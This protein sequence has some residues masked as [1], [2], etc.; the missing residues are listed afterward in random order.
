MAD[1][2]T[3]V[4]S[5]RI[6]VTPTATKAEIQKFVNDFQKMLSTAMSGAESP[7]EK[8]VEDFEDAG[9]EAAEKFNKEFDKTKP[10]KKPIDAIEKTTKQLD[11]LYAKMD[12]AQ[13][14]DE[15][16]G[17]SFA[18]GELIDQIEKVEKKLDKLK[19]PPIKV[20]PIDVPP[21]E[22]P[23]EDIAPIE[24][25]IEDIKIPD[26]I[27]PDKIT[28]PPIDA[29]DTSAVEEELD[30]IP[31]G[32]EGIGKKW[33]GLFASGI[34]AA[35]LGGLI[36][37]SIKVGLNF[38]SS[39]TNMS[40]ALGFT[41]EQAEIYGSLAGEL[42]GQAYG[43][44]LEEVQGVVKNIIA[45]FD[46]TGGRGD[47]APAGGELSDMARDVLLLSET[48]GLSQ[49]EITSS[50]KSFMD[51]GMG[52]W[53]EGVQLV[54]DGYTNMGSKGDDW[55][56]TIKEYSGDFK[57]LGL[58]ATSSF[59][60]VNG[61][62]QAGVYNTDTAA[63]SLREFAI[64]A[65]T[66]DQAQID[67]LG[68]LGLDPETVKAAAKEGGDAL[69]GAYVDVQTKLQESKDQGL[70][71]ALIG[72]QS[73]DQ[74]NAFVNADWSNLLNNTEYVANNIDDIN[75][76]LGET[77]ES[78][79]TALQRQFEMTLGEIAIPLLEALNPILSDF[80]AFLTENK[81]IIEKIAGPLLII[82][83]ILSTIITAII[84][85]GAVSFITNGVLTA[86]IASTWAWTVAL[87]ANPITWVVIAI[88]ALIAA[89]WLLITNWDVVT[90]AW[91]DIFA[92][93]FSWVT[94][95]WNG[96][97][98]FLGGIAI[99]LGGFWVDIISGWFENWANFFS[100]I[101]DGLMTIGGFFNG[102]AESVGISFSSIFAGIGDT[103]L[104]V[105]QRFAGPINWLIAMMNFLIDG[106][107]NIRIDV[108]SWVGT[109]LGTQVAPIGFNIPR[110]PQFKNGGT[111][112]PTEGG[113][114]GIFAEAGKAEAIMD[115]GK[116][117]TNLDLQNRLIDQIIRENGASSNKS[118]EITLNDESNLD[119][120]EMA[121]LLFQREQW[122]S[123]T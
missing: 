63:D 91:G 66:M 3:V 103:M 18:A 46:S 121:E 55:V 67:A 48:Y 43:S 79:L 22:I 98:G 13:K 105:V 123:N 81:D 69:V 2:I 54:I 119:T 75:T 19:F 92:G 115:E 32:G 45:S 21:V 17:D 5:A 88:I 120:R 102:L 50:I 86:M 52:S 62:L 29:P 37:E 68:V 90:K 72:T 39:A 47:W 44:S 77:G 101:G 15:N 74:F 34:V 42:Y 83:T 116:H 113:T 112:N 10:S 25:P 73:E 109:M 40:A 16:W 41:P 49:E 30:N 56:D 71:E 122:E 14:A 97:L 6:R 9:K 89:L 78:K 108:P 100:F 58:D 7:A 60:V 70:Y 64:R 99:S 8:V 95:V 38:E 33:A 85:W 76:K 117:N 110:I 61:L 51:N 57:A 104:S 84:A 93:F 111:I 36:G 107:N 87:L 82:G 65:R 11:K 28:L 80:S 27:P 118:V 53:H 24:I 31:A 4:G 12:E 59:K 35:H 23:I 94:E 20:P 114:L 96:F 26:I 106:L 1:E